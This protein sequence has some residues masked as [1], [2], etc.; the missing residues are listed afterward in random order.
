VE[1]VRRDVPRLLRPYLIFAGPV[2]RKGSRKSTGAIS[3]RE[4]AKE[5]E[6]ERTRNDVGIVKS[7]KLCGRAQSIPSN[8]DT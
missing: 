6:R 7:G 5:K 8:E 1:S 3:R 2:A 4:K